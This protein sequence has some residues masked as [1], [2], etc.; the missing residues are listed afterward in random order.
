MV[1]ISINLVSLLSRIPRH[2]AKMSKTV[3]VISIKFVSLGEF[4]L[5]IRDVVRSK[6]SFIKYMQHVSYVRYNR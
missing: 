1:I 2:D 3:F 6:A 5:N 4:T